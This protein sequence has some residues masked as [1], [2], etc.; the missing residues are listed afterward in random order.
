[1]KKNRIFR[2]KF[3]KTTKGIKRFSRFRI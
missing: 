1:M 3:N 2:L